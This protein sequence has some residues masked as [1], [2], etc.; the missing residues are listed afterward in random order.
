MSPKLKMYSE[1]QNLPDFKA[2]TGLEDSNTPKPPK[3]EAPFQRV[4]GWIRWPVR[5]MILPP[6]LLDY[7]MYKLLYLVVLPPYKLEGKCK[8][9]GNCCHFIHMDWST[10]GG[11]YPYLNMIRKIWNTEFLGFYFRDFAL[12]ENKKDRIKV[13]SCRYLK[14]DGSCGHYF[15]RPLV[16]RLWPRMN[17]FHKPGLIKGCGFEIKKRSMFPWKKKL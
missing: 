17:Y 11:I 7:W 15:L 3:K 8:Q 16:C 5:V 13:M 1:N 6:V 2:H 4:P 10:K 9:R 14:K 12:I